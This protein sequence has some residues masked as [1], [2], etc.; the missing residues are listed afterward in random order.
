M[1]SLEPQISFSTCT[2]SKKLITYTKGNINT[3]VQEN[4]LRVISII[5]GQYGNKLLIRFLVGGFVSETL[6][7]DLYSVNGTHTYY[8]SSVLPD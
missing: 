2:Q 8:Q 7:F 3:R 4:K 1:Y 5:F 6:L